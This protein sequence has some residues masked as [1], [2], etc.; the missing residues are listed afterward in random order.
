MTT[1]DVRTYEGYWLCVFGARSVEQAIVEFGLVAY[2]L[3]EWIGTAEDAAISQAALP[4][5]ETF[6]EWDRFHMRALREL[7][8]TIESMNAKALD[9]AQDMVHS[10]GL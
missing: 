5:A 7:N 4:R 2:G 9:E 3:D 6:F 10:V 8:Q 1:R